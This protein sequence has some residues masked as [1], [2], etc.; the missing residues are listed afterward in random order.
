[1]VTHLVTF[2]IRFGVILLLRNQLCTLGAVTM[3][4]M[5]EI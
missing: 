3:A 5:D 1:M 4:H 2:G